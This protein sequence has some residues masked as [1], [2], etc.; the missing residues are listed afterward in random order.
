MIV[1]R[2]IPVRSPTLPPSPFATHTTQP[3]IIHFIAN[4]KCCFALRPEGW[5]IVPITMQPTHKPSGRDG[6]EGMNGHTNIRGLN[7]IEFESLS[8]FSFVLLTD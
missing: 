5:L 4:R 8:R 3:C 7:S 1:T 2:V 6:E